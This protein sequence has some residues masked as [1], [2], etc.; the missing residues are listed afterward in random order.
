MTMRVSTTTFVDPRVVLTLDYIM[1]MDKVC[2]R[3][4]WGFGGFRVFWV[5]EGELNFLGLGEG[6]FRVRVIR[7]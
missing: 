7:V 2:P 6:W 3:R 5:G 1:S 4:I